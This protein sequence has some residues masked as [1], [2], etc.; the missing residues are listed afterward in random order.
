MQI[1]M[2]IF[3]SQNSQQWRSGKKKAITLIKICNVDIKLS[4]KIKSDLE[5]KL[6]ILNNYYTKQF[7]LGGN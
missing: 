5:L 1:C 7:P 2:N 4:I 6:F 3:Y